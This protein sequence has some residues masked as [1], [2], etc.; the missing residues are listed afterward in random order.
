MAG[1]VE[2]YYILKSDDETACQDWDASK[3]VLMS[4]NDISV[5]YLNDIN[6]FVF[7]FPAV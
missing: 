3:S 4:G 1:F 6:D 2:P 7:I 5:S